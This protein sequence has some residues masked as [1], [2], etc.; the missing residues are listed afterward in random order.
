MEEALDELSLIVAENTPAMQ[1]ITRMR[2]FLVNFPRQTDSYIFSILDV[3]RTIAS[4]IKKDKIV[5]ALILTC[6]NLYKLRDDELFWKMRTKTMFNL[7]LSEYVFSYKKTYYYYYLS[8]INRDQDKNYPILRLAT[9]E[10]WMIPFNEQLEWVLE[11]YIEGTSKENVNILLNELLAISIKNNHLE[12]IDKLLSVK[13]D[14]TFKSYSG[15][16]KVARS[17]LMCDILTLTYIMKSYVW[18]DYMIE[19]IEDI[20]NDALVQGCNLN[21]VELLLNSG[22]NLNLNRNLNEEA[23]Y[24]IIR[25]YKRIGGHFSKF[26]YLHT[27]AI[28]S[29]LIECDK[30]E[31][32]IMIK[33]M[34]SIFTNE[35]K[36]K[37][38]LPLLDPN[39]IPNNILSL[40][41]PRYG[42]V[43]GKKMIIDILPATFVYSNLDKCTADLLKY[44]LKKKGLKVSGKKADIL[45]RIK[46]SQNGII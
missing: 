37:E 41:G 2:K 14:K 11:D 27:N 43:E 40:L 39:K 34:F 7:D 18:G 1:I 25:Y 44:I 15:W 29:V 12:M 38:I 8:L 19:K 28:I 24:M 31:L 6:K 16:N 17:L 35:T 33:G 46:D 21:N 36:L 4:Y 42:G 22:C 45:Q 3:A 20:M 9:L 13:K 32:A 10:G 30:D 26:I 5:T 23:S